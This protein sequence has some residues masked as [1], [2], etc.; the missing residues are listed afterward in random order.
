METPLFVLIVLLIIAVAIAVPIGLTVAVF[1][2]TRALVSG[3]R[4]ALAGLGLGVALLVVAYGLASFFGGANAFSPGFCGGSANG[5]TP[6]DG[7][8]GDRDGVQ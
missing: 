5:P 4:R 3:E 8:D 6:T 2:T 1:V 7:C